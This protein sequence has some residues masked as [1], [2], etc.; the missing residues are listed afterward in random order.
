MELKLNIFHHLWASMFFLCSIL[1]RIFIC[2]LISCFYFSFILE[3][4]YI[5]NN[6]KRGQRTTRKVSFSTFKSILSIFRIFFLPIFLTFL[7]AKKIITTLYSLIMYVPVLYIILKFC[8][9]IFLQQSP[10][11]TI[12]YSIK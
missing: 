9:K 8:N 5:S 2:K 4:M 3:P 10:P 1:K 12:F 7:N 11:P 6:R